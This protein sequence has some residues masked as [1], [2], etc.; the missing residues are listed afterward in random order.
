MQGPP[1]DSRNGTLPDNRALP[2]VRWLFNLYC[3]HVL[4]A[5]GSREPAKL[6]IRNKICDMC[7]ASGIQS[8]GLMM[9]ATC[10]IGTALWGALS[11]LR[12]ECK[13][14]V[15]IWVCGRARDPYFVIL[16]GSVSALGIFFDP[17]PT[18]DH[19]R[20]CTKR[21]ATIW[22]SSRPRTPYFVIRALLLFDNRYFDAFFTF[23]IWY[24]WI[25][26]QF[27]QIF[28]HFLFVSTTS[29]PYQVDFSPPWGP[30]EGRGDV[31]NTEFAL[32]SCDVRQKRRP[33]RFI[34]A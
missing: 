18:G 25:T 26:P 19:F 23:G 1:D 5:K 33:N 8:F 22:T 17:C 6:F 9:C 11:A 14:S 10:F 16:G 20:G 7:S 31:A 30:R 4:R 2:P 21:S 24:I 13:H 27:H 32:C 29:T 3:A 34:A 28:F 12:A 15:T